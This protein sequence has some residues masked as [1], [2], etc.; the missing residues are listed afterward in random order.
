M[1][2]NNDEN[3]GASFEEI[4]DQEAGKLLF[5]KNNARTMALKDLWMEMLR[6]RFVQMKVPEENWLEELFVTL[7][8]SMLDLTM[9]VVTEET[10]LELAQGVDEFL[11]V[12]LVNQKY[13]TD[14]ML[15]FQREFIE[16]E[17]SEFVSEDELNQ[18]LESFEENWFSTKRESL[19]NRSPWLVLKEMSDKYDL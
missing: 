10:A 4:K 2:D 19:E 17:G 9:G 14:L 11:K 6:N 13:D 7:S 1:N 18:A 3:E 8:R 5:D 15:D 12:A 16:A